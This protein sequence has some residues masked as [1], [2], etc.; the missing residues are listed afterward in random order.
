MPLFSNKAV[1]IFF[2]EQ[3]EG[4]PLVLLS[5]LGGDHQSVWPPCFE[6][7]AKHFRV[8]AVDTR[9]SGKSQFFEDPFTIQD[10]ADDIKQLLDGLNIDRI[11][12]AGYSMGGLVAQQFAKD[13]PE[14]LDRL[15]LAGTYSRMN[16][17]T[18]LFMEGVREAY[19]GSRSLQTIFDLVYPLLY[20]EA[21]YEKIPH[22]RERIRLPPEELE[23]PYFGWLRL[24]EALRAFDS[25]KWLHDI[26]H[27]TLII[28]GTEDFFVSLAD[29]ELLEKKIPDST[30]VRIPEAGHMLSYEQT[31][32]FLSAILNFLHS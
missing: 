15:I 7:F 21:Y 18:C 30:V 6:P 5:G 9:N 25:R 16:N 8:I 20:R 2:Y 3:G 24:Y 4:F 10:M 28:N 11:H 1:E 32:R 19:E 29:Q 27:K 23:E 17:R 22:G 13:Y 26:K 14:Y 12:L 31:E